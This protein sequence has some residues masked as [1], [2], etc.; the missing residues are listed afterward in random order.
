MKLLSFQGTA[1]RTTG[2][3]VDGEVIDLAAVGKRLRAPLDGLSLRDMNSIIAGGAR[4]LE[5]VAQL[6]AAASS[7]ERQPLAKVKLLAPHQPELILASGGNYSDHRQEKEEALLAG[8]EPEFFFKLPRGVIGPLAGVELDPRVTLKLDYEVELAVV[9]GRLGRHIRE[10]DALEHVFG[11][12]VLND[13]TARDRQVRKRDGFTWYESGASKNFDT[14][15]PMGPVIVTRDEI[16]DPQAL[17]VSTTVN[18]ELRQSNSTSNMTFGVAKLV[19]FFSTFMT[20][21]PGYV[22]TTGT[23]GGTAWAAD[24]ELGGK[25]YTRGDIVRAKG[26]LQVGDVVRCEVERIGM[27][28]NRVVAPT[29]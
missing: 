12:T 23:P 24:T 29:A 15:C 6:A 25:P 4:A 5:T 17:K 16:P 20:L 28:E 11:Y 13:I 21:H 8:K 7:A 14:S 22:I 10:A 27:L 2:L 3:L 1:G 19:S 26:Y 9:I 18:G